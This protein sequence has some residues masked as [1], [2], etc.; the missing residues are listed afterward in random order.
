MPY[1]RRFLSA[2]PGARAHRLTLLEPRLSAETAGLAVGSGAVCAFVND[3]LGAP[4]LDRM[5]ADGVP[6]V[7]LRQLQQQWRV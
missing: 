7:A 4:V 1:D 5:A 3:E 2:A 6:L